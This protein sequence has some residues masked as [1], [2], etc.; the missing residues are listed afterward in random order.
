MIQKKIL[1]SFIALFC[2]LGVRGYTDAD[3]R[4]AN[5]EIQRLFDETGMSAL[6][7]A[8]T[9]GDSIIYAQSFGYRVLPDDNHPGE[10]LSNDDLFVIASVSKTFIATAIMKLQ[11]DG[12]LDIDEDAQKYLPFPLRNPTHPD[13]VITIRQ[14]I[15]HTSGINDNRSWWNIDYINPERDKEYYKCFSDAEPGKEYDY[16]NM[17]Y[18]LLGAILE[19]VAGKR[20]DEVID[21]TIIRPLN[22]GGSFNVNYINRSRL[23]NLYHHD[24]E[25]GGAMIM[26]P[27]YYKPYI[28][29]IM[30]N[31]ELGRSLGLEYP[32]SGMKITPSDL[33]VF[34]RM[35]SNDG[36][37]RGVRIISKESEDE[38]RRN[39][40]GSHNYGLSFRHYQDFIPGK[41][42]YG[43]TGGSQGT[44]TAMIF[45]PE[46]QIG[47]VIFES[48]A[49]TKDRDAY[50]EV[51]KPIGQILYK[52]LFSE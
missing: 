13:K 16:C 51:H 20:F 24:D 40:V 48:G 18:T 2:A 25:N 35:H 22:I 34:M 37:Y 21:E 14:L 47:F 11:E 10:L 12:M 19:M 43:Q 41:S 46:E 30:R 1:L 27:E 7:I 52:Y 31:Y 42:M 9:R 8:V 5:E 23:T 36:E 28:P 6:G 33:T 29:Q 44:K 3:L 45:D 17:N 50:S 26:N 15:N 49:R 4:N 39:Y 38:M 32:A